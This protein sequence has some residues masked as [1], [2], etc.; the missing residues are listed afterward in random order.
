M[1]D[2]L[3]PILYHVLQV[4]FVGCEDL[5]ELALL[6]EGL[7]VLH[8]GDLVAV[9]PG[10]G[11][12]V[13]LGE[14]IAVVGVTGVP[15]GLFFLLIVIIDAFAV[16]FELLDEF[17]YATATNLPRCSCLPAS[18]LLG[19]VVT[20]ASWAACSIFAIS[21]GLH[22]W[23]LGW[24]LADAPLRVDLLVGGAAVVLIDRWRSWA[25][26]LRLGSLHDRYLVLV[27]EALC[28]ETHAGALV[29]G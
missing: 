19:R 9:E 16:L 7:D 22:L 1:L 18:I 15:E 8:R 21:L 17:G 29:G 27:G 14:L 26:A 6:T 25:R 12:N 4:E 2:E 24:W 5:L 20:L 23:W 11:V 10:K 3:L 28:G 13:E